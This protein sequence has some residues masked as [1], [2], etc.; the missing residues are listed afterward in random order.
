MK[1]Y[2]KIS[3]FLFSVIL[4]TVLA[5]DKE[6]IADNPGSGEITEATL[7]ERIDNTGELAIDLYHQLIEPGQNLLISPH[8]IAIT[9]GMVYAGARS[10]T[11]QEISDVLN[12]HYPQQG[13]HPALKELNDILIS[14]G[15][16]IDPESF[17]LSIV[18]GCW[19]RDDMSYQQ[20]YL[21]ILLEYYGAAIENM[22]FMFQP[23]ES[24]EAINQ[25]VEDQTEGKVEDLIPPGAIDSYTYLV[26]ANTIY[27]KAS[28][29]YQFDPSMTFD[30]PFTLI[31]GAEIS[32]PMMLGEETFAFFNGS[33]YKAVEIPYIGEEV[34]MLIL[35]PDEGQFE[36]FEASITTEQIAMITD[37]LAAEHIKLSLP[38]FSFISSHDLVPVLKD[39]GMVQAFKL[40][41]ADFSGMDGT[42]DGSPFISFVVHKTFISVDEFGTEAAAATGMGLAL[43]SIPDEFVASRPFIFAIR[44]TETGTILFL[45]RVVDPQS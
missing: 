3:C 1:K 27:F 23:E 10:H 25:W 5:C 2:S 6:K 36:S 8:S 34:S 35:L 15:E 29:F 43:T 39:M 32:V 41:E 9:F 19:G 13:F 22:D 16:G 30:M 21:D 28:W 38:K 17:R 20:A 33:G 24:R 18:N 31:G 12:F 37:D 42:D 7:G 40:G 14:R 45:G 11:E 44:D 26:L 4:L